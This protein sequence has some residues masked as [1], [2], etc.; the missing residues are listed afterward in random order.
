MGTTSAELPAVNNNAS[1][2]TLVGCDYVVPF[3]TRYP[4]YSWSTK[5][6]PAA[7]MS[8]D[9]SGDN[10]ASMF[11]MNLFAYQSAVIQCLTLTSYMCLPPESS[12]NAS[13]AGILVE[14]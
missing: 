7:D 8:E 5:V 14:Q 10:S 11:D 3:E 6:A 2:L 1:T 4:M 13:T 9:E 12:F